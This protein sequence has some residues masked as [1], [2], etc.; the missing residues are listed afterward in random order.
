MSAYYNEFD[1]KA[2]AWLRELIKEGHIADGDVDTRSI[3]EVQPDDLEGYGQVHFFA[4][5]GGWS[6]ALRLAGVPDTDPVWTGS[7]PCQPYSS[8]GKQKGKEDH[9][10]LWPDMFRLVRQRRP[11]RVFGEQV[12]AAIGHGWLDGVFA[13]ME[14]EGYACGA[15]VLGAHSVGA[16]HIRQ[17]VFWVSDAAYPKH[18]DNTSEKQNHKWYLDVERVGLPRE[19][20]RNCT[21]GGLRDADIAGLEGRGLLAGECTGE[22]P[23]RPASVWDRYDIIPFGDGKARR[24]ISRLALLADGVSHTM[25]PVRNQRKEQIN[26]TTKKAGPE[27]S[28][29]ELSSGDDPENDRNTTRGLDRVYSSE[30]LQPSL[31]GGLDGRENQSTDRE[32]Q[33]ADGIPTKGINLLPMRNEQ[34]AGVPPHRRES[35]E[36]RPLELDGVVRH[37][38]HAHTLATVEKDDTTAQALLALFASSPA[39]RAVQ[40]PLQPV[41]PARQSEYHDA[42]ERAW[43]AGVFSR[44]GVIACNPLCVNMPGRVGLLRGYG[45]AIVPQVA[46]EF[47][48]AVMECVE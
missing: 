31:H 48:K 24:I 14:G 16:P 19:P 13:D 21:T 42:V 33:Q 36:Q 28:V 2:A 20:R 5:I 32:E 30:V 10:H 29:Q 46:A 38:P 7:C 43:K 23:A 25:A 47:V 39:L 26:A 44:W 12:A 40:H 27:E 37:L 1:P 17:R 8:A 11:A 22:R 41:S 45:N 3:T 4:G 35:T 6:L 15:V 34:Q 18:K 9:R